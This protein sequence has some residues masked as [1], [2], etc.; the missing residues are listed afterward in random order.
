MAETLENEA[1]I[2]D[3]I[4]ILSELTGKLRYENVRMVRRSPLQMV[5]VEHTTETVSRE[6]ADRYRR[7][8]QDKLA[9][10]LTQ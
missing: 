6:L 3:P 5:Q 10:K 2:I 1:N 4:W 9:R 7:I 8:L